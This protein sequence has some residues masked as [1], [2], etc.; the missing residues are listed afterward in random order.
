MI[1][2]TDIEIESGGSR[3][4]FT[5]LS[6]YYLEETGFKALAKPFMAP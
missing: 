4:P 5:P 6:R 2:L 3:V 1:I